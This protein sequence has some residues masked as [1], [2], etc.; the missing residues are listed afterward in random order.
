MNY[1]PYT[2]TSGLGPKIG[3]AIC[4]CADIA[5]LPT[6]SPINSVAPVI[7][8]NTTRGSTLT[9]TNGTW[10][11]NPSPTFTYQ[12]FRGNTPIPTQ[13]NMTYVIELADGGQPITCRVTSSNGIGSV[14]GISN[15]ITPILVPFSPINSVAHV[16]SGNTIHGSTLT[17]TNGTWFGNPSPTFTYQWFRGN[18]PIPN[19]TNMTYVTQ[20]VDGGQPIT[21]R[22]TGTNNIGSVVVISNVITPILDPTQSITFMGVGNS[23]T[24]YVNSLNQVVTSPVASGFTIYRVTS[25]S[26]GTT[27]LV[28]S[29]SVS[30]MI[31]FLVIGGGGSSGPFGFNFFGG[32]GT[33]GGGGGG[34]G[35]IESSRTTNSNT[36]YSMYV[37]RG[38]NGGN[39]E[40]SLLQ[41]SSETL[42]AIGGGGGGGGTNVNGFDGG[43]GGGGGFII[44]NNTSTNGLGGNGVPG[45]GFSGAPANLADGSAGAGGGA[46]GSARGSG[47]PG[48]PSTITGQT[49]FY[50]GGGGS[51][52]EAGG[53]GGGGTG[54]PGTNGL[55]GGGGVR[56][57]PGT[58][59]GD[60][61]VILRIPSFI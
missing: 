1:V 24:I 42:T 21:C 43:S 29:N 17:T 16:I 23:E 27:Y 31:S 11:G 53:I 54:T 33:R 50:A 12:W 20:I 48:L 61:V 47:G 22:V 2:D 19:Q 57:G 52:N 14:V 44:N 3:G 26:Q 34:G 28:N 41:L 15:V 18:T 51:A 38:G 7:S 35:F 6:F 45:Q 56:F 5:L 58:S 49:I 13:T 30:T 37:G 8:G 40:N 46:G 55:G 36:I 59:G 10:L 39:G 9:T 60:G 32:G 4:N 25:T